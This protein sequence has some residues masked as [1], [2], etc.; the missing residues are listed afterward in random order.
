MSDSFRTDVFLR[1]SPEN[2]ACACIY[3]SARELQIPLPQNP[4]WYTVFGADEQSLNAISVRI[5]HLYSHK[6]VS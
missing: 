5:L 1:Y 4:P 2:I 6:T 3:L